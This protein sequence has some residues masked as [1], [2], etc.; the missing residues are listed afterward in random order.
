MEFIDL[1]RLYCCGSTPLWLWS[2]TI[3]WSLASVISSVFFL[4][5]DKL[6]LKIFFTFVLFKE[7]YSVACFLLL[8]FSI[9]AL[10]FLKGDSKLFGSSLNGTTVPFPILIRPIL[11][12]RSEP[13]DSIAENW[14]T[15]PPLRPLS[16]VY[17]VA[18]IVLML[19]YLFFWDKVECGLQ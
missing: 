12:L 1:R 5:T 2:I 19:E 18:F 4:S 8:F 13:D 17:V 11:M 7:T 10:F 9:Y 15:R 3:V 14:F 6:E 16:N